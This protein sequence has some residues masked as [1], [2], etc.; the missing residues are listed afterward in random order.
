MSKLKKFTFQKLIVFKS[1]PL[2][3]F[4]S[5]HARLKKKTAIE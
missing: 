3:E 2:Q 1:K 4:K 5:L